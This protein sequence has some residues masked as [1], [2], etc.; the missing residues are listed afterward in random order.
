MG[1]GLEGGAIRTEESSLAVSAVTVERPKQLRS[2]PPP[3]IKASLCGVG[4]GGSAWPLDGLFLPG[5][6]AVRPERH[7]LCSF[8]ALRHAGVTF[9]LRLRPGSVCAASGRRG[10]LN[11]V[12]E[13][14]S[15]GAR[16][17]R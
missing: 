9:D 16:P 8:I 1:A 13:Q 10:G 15:E 17:P 2:A 12:M 7:Q 6:A 5:E 4:G 11:G 14:R 3:N